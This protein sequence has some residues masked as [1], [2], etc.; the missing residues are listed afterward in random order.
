[1]DFFPGYPNHRKSERMANDF[2]NSKFVLQLYGGS[3]AI[4]T[5]I[6]LLYPNSYLHEA[7][8]V[9]PCSLVKH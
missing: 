7:E 9:F 3:G 1:M 8:Y 5:N 4:G 2:P 6:K